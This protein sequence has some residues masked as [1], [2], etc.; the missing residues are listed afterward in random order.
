[1]VEAIFEYQFLQRALLVGLIVGFICPLIGVFI[2][3]RRLSVIGEALSHMSLSGI[4]IGSM[5]GS[6]VPFFQSVGPTFYSMTFAV[7]GAFIVEWLRKVY[8]HFSEIAIPILLSFGVGLSVV[9]FS[10]MDGLNVDFAGYLFGN[11]LA[12][13]K[14]ELLLTIVIG[15]IVLMTIGLFYKEILVVTFDPEFSGILGIRK[16]AIDFL[17][18]VILALTISVTVRAVG[19]MLVSGLLILPPAA[20]ML[21]SSSFKRTLFISIV[22]GEISIILGLFT[23]YYFSL[24]TGGTIIMFG[25]ILLL[26]I[27]FVKRFFMRPIDIG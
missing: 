10:A 27:L 13:S 20:A 17:F 24:A 1:M 18:I 23:S 19:V 21:I 6:F 15:F 12:V 26:L 8:S 5:L 16:N 2:V 25:L 11:L 14:L 22:I 7:I 4:A 3:A 9:L